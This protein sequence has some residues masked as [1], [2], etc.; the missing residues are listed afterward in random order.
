MTII[1][2]LDWYIMRKFLG[3]FLL[4]IVL[5]MAITI[6]FDLTEKLDKL[7]EHNAPLDK[8]VFEYYLNLLPFYFN[9][10]SPLFVFI[11]VIFF[12]SKLA[13]NSEIIAMQA[14]GISFRRMLLPYFMSAS[15]IAI[16]TFLF[17]SYIIPPAN[18]IRLKFENQYVK[19]FKND[20]VDNVQME[21][22]KG[23]ILYIETFDI[24]DKEGE[25]LFLEKYEGKHLVSRMTA[26]KVYWD[27]LTHWQVQNYTIRNFNGLKE[28]LIHSNP[29]DKLDTIINV[30]PQDLFVTVKEA[31]Q[32]NNSELSSYIERQRERGLGNIKAFES[33]YYTR[34][35]NSFAA[36]ILTLIGV[37]LSAK[38]VRGGTGANLGIGI[39]L[40]A[41][42]V[43][44]QTFS[45]SFAVNGNM[46]S[47]LAAWLPNI[48]FTFIALFLYRN[49]PK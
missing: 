21:V 16:F 6:V 25:N 30:E 41:T 4:S 11:S 20:Y 17:G 18:K 29:N 49:A 32:M 1:K 12:T 2:K 5:I 37:S 33:E 40:S 23:E 24:N 47:L 7:S 15:I 8:I 31:P 14:S 38:K 9:M 39:G 28:E 42:Y 13:G 43:L 44:F 48:I 10:F 34:F 36:F 46:P 19:K 22:E 26:K 3:T 27:T 35:S 45:T